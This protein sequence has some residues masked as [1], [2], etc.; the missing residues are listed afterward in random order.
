MIFVNLILI[1]GYL[2]Y[3]LKKRRLS[4]VLS[5]FCKNKIIKNAAREP[6]KETVCYVL[7]PQ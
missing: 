1:S 4:S 6:N 7:K 3:K 2:V 5:M